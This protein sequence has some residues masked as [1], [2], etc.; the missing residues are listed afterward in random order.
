MGEMGMFKMGA[1]LAR[2]PGVR[3]FR[4]GGLL[5][6]G[7]P[8]SLQSSSTQIPVSIPPASVSLGGS[9]NLFFITLAAPVGFEPAGHAAVVWP[10]LSARWSCRP[11]GGNAGLSLSPATSDTGAR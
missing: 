4:E 10:S 1:R 7:V 5:E 3:L 8:V 9:A 6:K 11:W 2:V